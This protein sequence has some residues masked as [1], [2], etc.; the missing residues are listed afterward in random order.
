MLQ[1]IPKIDTWN[2][3]FLALKRTRD[4]YINMNVDS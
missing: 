3:D 4:K 1:D 2:I